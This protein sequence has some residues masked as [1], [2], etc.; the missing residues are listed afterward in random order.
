M[1]R[2]HRNRILESPPKMEGFSPFGIH[3]KCSECII[4]QFDEYQ[5]FIYINYNQLQQDV[6]AEKMNVSRPTFTRIY[7][8]ALQK[9]ALAFAE[10]KKIKI[11]G[12]NV[13]FEKKWYRCK[14]CHKLFSELENHSKCDNCSHFGTDELLKIGSQE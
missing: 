11:I 8:N 2:P 4:L 13:L 1:A 9:I 10:G 7:N 5:S 6:A 3:Q 12:G 14:R